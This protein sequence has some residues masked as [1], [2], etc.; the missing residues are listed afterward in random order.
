MPLEDRIGFV[1]NSSGALERE[2]FEKA[3]DCIDEVLADTFTANHV[4]L[5]CSTSRP[6]S[7]KNESRYLTEPRNEVRKLHVSRRKSRL[8]CHRWW[9]DRSFSTVWQSSLS[10]SPGGRVVH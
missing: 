5:I 2:A 3:G 6:L 9:V 10:Y 7:H 4:G 1:P 8:V